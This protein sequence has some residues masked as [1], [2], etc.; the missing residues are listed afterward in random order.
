MVNSSYANQG[1]LQEILP[2]PSLNKSG[3]PDNSGTFGMSW[4]PGYAI[5]VE[6]GERLNLAF[7]EDTALFNHNGNDGRFNPDSIRYENGNPVFGGRHWLYIFQNQDRYFPG[8]NRMP[9]YDEGVYAQNMLNGTS[10]DKIKFWRSTSWSGSIM[11]GQG[12]DFLQC[13]VTLKIRQFEPFNFSLSSNGFDSTGSYFIQIPAVMPVSISEKSTTDFTIFPNPSESG[14]FNYSTNEKIIS[15]E[16]YDV[17]GKLVYKDSN[18]S[19]E[20]KINLSVYTSGIYMIRLSDKNRHYLTRK[21]MV[22]R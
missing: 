5:N 19:K 18:P 22:Q 7:S 13:D 15:L 14:L 12:F 3:L 10:S 9:F 16:I 11:P 4:F 17:T 1:T 20:G 6:T 2:F 21:I 8:Q